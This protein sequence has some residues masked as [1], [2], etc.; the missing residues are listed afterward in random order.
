MMC[1]LEDVFRALA[2]ERRRHV[3]VCL[4][5]HHTVSLADLAEFVVERERDESL[6]EISAEAIR[7][8]YFGLYHNHV[9]VLEEADLVRYE[10]EADVVAQTEQT[11]TRLSS[12]RDRL[13]SLLVA[14]E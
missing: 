11:T 1:E 3:L 5:E 7:D 2:D 9:P 10:Q 8:V 12:L 6:A 4:Q 13:D 14:L